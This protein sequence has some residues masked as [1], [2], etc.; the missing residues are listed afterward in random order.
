[1]S[2]NNQQEPQANRGEGWRFEMLNRMENEPNDKYTIPKKWRFGPVLNQDRK[3]TDKCC[4]LIFLLY[5][6]MMIASTFTALGRSSH[7]DLQKLYDS[8]NNAC[9]FEET[10]EYPILFMQNF[11]S[12]YKSVCVKA[13]PKFDYNAIKYG[14]DSPE[15]PGPLYYDT[16]KNQL[17]GKSFTHTHDY[18]RKE[19]FGF[20]EGFAN[21]YYTK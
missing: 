9:G 18:D 1:M 12:P 4:L 15:Y 17:A 19:A 21:G 7:E 6:T 16:F 2:G 14:K 3:M 20:D 11:E 13:C 10:K 5:I 8:S